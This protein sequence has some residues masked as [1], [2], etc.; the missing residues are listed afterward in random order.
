MHRLAPH[1][2][3]CSLAALCAALVPA[4]TSA[5]AAPRFRFGSGVATVRPAPMPHTTPGGRLGVSDWVTCGVVPT[6]AGTYVV[7]FQLASFDGANGAVIGW[8]DERTLG[9]LATFASR[10][11]GTGNLVSGWGAGGNPITVS[12]SSQLLVSS[13][14]DGTLG[15][16][17]F[18]TTISDTAYTYSH[19]LFLQRLTGAGVPAAGYPAGG[20]LMVTGDVNVAGIVYD[21]AAG[22]FFGWSATGSTIRVKRL[23]NTGAVIGGWPVGGIDTGVSDQVNG[24]PALDGSGGVYLVWSTPTEVRIQRFVSTG[25]ASGWPAGGLVVSTPGSEVNPRIVRLSNNDALVAWEDPGTSHVFAMRVNAAGSLNGSWPAGGK[26]VSTAAGPQSQPHLLPDGADGV[27][28]EWHEQP[29]FLFG[30]P[31]VQRLTSLGAASAGWP[32]AG[33]PLI[34]VASEIA[35]SEMMPDGAGG[36]IVSWTDLRSSS[37]A[38]VYAMRVL[39]GGTVDAGW[40]ADGVAVCAAAGDQT[41]PLMVPDGAGGAI[42]TWL[43]YTNQI[44]PQVHAARLLNDGTVSALASLVDAAAEPG[45]VALHW[46]TPDGSVSC[47][48][49]ARRG[50]RRV[51]GVGRSAGRWRR[52]PALRGPH[53]RG[54]RHVPLPARGA[55]RRCHHL[56]RPGHD[57]GAGRGLVRDRRVPA[58]PGGGRGERGVRPGERRARAARVAGCG[59]APRAGGRRGVTGR[60]T[61]RAAAREGGGTPGGRLRAPAHAV[62]AGGEHARDDRAIEVRRG[63]ARGQITSWSVTVSVA[64]R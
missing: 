54:R 51:R 41:F 63:G 9:K 1:V 14:L 46:Y 42:V 30:K 17:F 4:P 44:D 15:G 8:T 22:L 18:L 26:Q 45:R 2:V 37:D 48:G 33:V 13:G 39:A 25:V 29:G 59:R 47:H 5:G 52:T 43:D 40:T 55:G 20:K 21:G 35:S 34:S 7:P 31:Y 11:S 49:R 12:D 6:P 50:G 53:R 38:D 36:A 24:E 16:G 10:L 60:R 56:P 28:V 3:L 61:A 62:G 19:D 27:F 58:Q 64:A 57:P 23:D 32:A